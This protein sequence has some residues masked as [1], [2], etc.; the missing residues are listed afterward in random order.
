MCSETQAVPVAAALAFE[1]AAFAEPLSVCRHAAHQAASLLGKRVLVSG[2]G[3]IG[4]LAEVDR[5]RVVT[6]AD[7]YFSD[8]G[9]TQ[10]SRLRK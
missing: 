8:T 4:A 1:T 6:L 3:L 10:K 7:G 9:R 5:Q 2:T